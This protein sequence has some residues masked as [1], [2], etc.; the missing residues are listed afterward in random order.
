MSRNDF[1]TGINNEQEAI[2]VPGKERGER[3]YPFMHQESVWIEWYASEEELIKN[4][5]ADRELLQQADPS[6]KLDIVEPKGILPVVAFIVGMMSLAALVR[7]VSDLVCRRRSHGLI[8]DA[9]IEPLKIRKIKDLPGG[10]VIVIAKDGTSRNYNVC[11]GKINL[12]TLIETVSHSA[13]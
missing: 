13:L 4:L 11:D 5:E 2:D 10:T 1:E 9:Q 3:D 7:E 6:A 8:I 12:A